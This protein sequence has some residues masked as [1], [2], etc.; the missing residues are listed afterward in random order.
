M[1]EAVCKESAWNAVADQPHRVGLRKAVYASDL[2]RLIAPALLLATAS[3]LHR[4]AFAKLAA[5]HKRLRQVN[6]ER[7]LLPNVGPSRRELSRH[8][9]YIAHTWRAQ[10]FLSSSPPT[11]A[12]QSSR[13]A[14][15]RRSDDHITSVSP[16][17]RQ[18]PDHGCDPASEQARAPC[19][20]RDATKVLLVFPKFNEHSFWNLRELCE[21]HW[22]RRRSVRKVR[23]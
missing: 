19:A 18:L 15:C 10:A 17:N 2:P 9:K 3:P 6:R 8:L 14:N 23:S 12:R 20:V 16:W 11:P 4:H 22:A 21:I 1:S 13:R 5:Q 7:S